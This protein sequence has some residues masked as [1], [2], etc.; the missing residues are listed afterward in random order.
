MINPLSFPVYV[1]FVLSSSFVYLHI[2]LILC[3]STLSFDSYFF[4]VFSSYF[5]VD[6]FCLWICVPFFSTV[7][8]IALCFLLSPVLFV[9]FTQFFPLRFVLSLTI[10]VGISLTLFLCP[11]LFIFTIFFLISCIFSYH[12]SCVISRSPSYSSHIIHNAVPQE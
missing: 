3:V 4:V 5:H 12:L 2:I 7:L 9:Y 10:F 6:C 8:L 1:Y 11:I